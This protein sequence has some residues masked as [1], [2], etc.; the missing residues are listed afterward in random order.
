MAHLRV[1]E[2]WDDV[3]RSNVMSHNK[4]EENVRGCMN[5]SNWKICVML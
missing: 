1:E 4:T 5:L 3:A 2:F